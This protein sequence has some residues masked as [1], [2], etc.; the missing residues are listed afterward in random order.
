[1]H[2]T[3]NLRTKNLTAPLWG[4]KPL[5]LPSASVFTKELQH[6]AV[7][8]YDVPC[9]RVRALVPEE[10]EL[11]PQ[12]R[13]SIESFLDAGGAPFAQTNYRLHVRQQG[14]VCHWLLGLSLGSLSGVTARHLYPLPWHLSAMELRV[15]A[16]AYRLSSQSQWASAHWELVEMSNSSGW[17]RGGELTDYFVRRDGEIGSYQTIYHAAP[18]TVGVLQHGRCELLESLGIL[19]RAELAWPVSVLLQP[20]VNCEIKPAAYPHRMRLAA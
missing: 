2:Y 19:S 3:S 6:R 9:E 5:A 11:A 7:I 18:S 10:F 12:T 20:A 16:S 17:E 15:A 13:L 8:H 14:K 4:M 1:M